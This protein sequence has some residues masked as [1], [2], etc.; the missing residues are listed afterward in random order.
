MSQASLRGK[1]VTSGSDDCVTF[2]TRDTVKCVTRGF[3]DI[4]AAACVI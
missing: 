1:S 2:A 3:Y 4:S